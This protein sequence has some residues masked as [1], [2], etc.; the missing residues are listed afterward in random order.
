ML[1]V[2]NTDEILHDFI[3]VQGTLGVKFEK[4]VS[5]CKITCSVMITIKTDVEEFEGKKT[6]SFSGIARRLKFSEDKQPSPV[7]KK[8]N[9]KKF[10]KKRKKGPDIIFTSGFGEFLI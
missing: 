7:K 1:N 10:F 3:K 5:L 2:E 9:F 6:F 4:E 8:F